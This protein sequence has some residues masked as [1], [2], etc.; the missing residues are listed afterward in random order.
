MI[1]VVQIYR[2]SKKWKQIT[3]QTP[4]QVG[5]TWLFKY[6]VLQRNESK[7]QL[8][9]I[10]LKLDIS[11]SNIPFFKEMK[12]NHNKTTGRTVR[13]KVVQIYRSSKK[14][15]QI[16]TFCILLFN[17]NKLFKYTVLQRNESKSQPYQQW[18]SERCGCSNIP[19]FKEMKANHN[20]ITQIVSF[21]KVVQIYRSSKKWKQIT[22]RDAVLLENLKLFKYTVLQRNESKSQQASPIYIN[23]NCCSNIP[24]FK[25]MKANHNFLRSGY[26]SRSVVQI[27]RSS[28]KWKQI[29]TNN[30]R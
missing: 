13:D 2:S 17:I 24:F 10:G 18:Y 9:L 23:S 1:R 26:P 8:I 19:F 15:K 22:T 21:R 29:T 16:T 5:V 28:K 12:A 14:W 11:C 25:E 30:D 20:S 4:Q 7:S 3:T 6:T 27:Y